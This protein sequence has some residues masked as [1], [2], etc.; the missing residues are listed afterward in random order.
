MHDRR[1]PWLTILNQKSVRTLIAALVTVSFA[2][3]GCDKV[4]G[5]VE[6]GKSLV[7][8]EEPAVADT[9]AVVDPA[10]APPAITTPEPVVPAGPTPQ[11]IVEQFTALRPGEITDGS[12]AQLAS[13]P[14]AAAAI[15]EIDMRG[16][17]VSVSGLKFLGAL[18][19][20]ETLKAS[21]LPVT[22]DSLTTIGKVQSLKNLDLS[23]SGANDQVISELSQIPHLQTLNLNGTRVTGGSA[24]GLG[25]MQ[26]L[27]EL[28]LVGTAADDLVVA[29]LASLPIR[30]LNLAKTQITNASLPHILKIKTL[31]SLNVSFCGV[32]G[33]GFKGFGK[34]DIKELDV[35]ETRF[36]IEGFMAIRGMSALE[37]LSVY[38]AGLV[39]HKSANVFRTFPKLKILNAGKN[40]LTDAG[41]HVFFKGHKTLEELHLQLNKGITDNGLAALIGVKTLRLLD[42][43]GTSCGAAGAQALKAKLPECTIR[44][45]NGQF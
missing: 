44:T 26:E 15:T 5:L 38:G 21:N 40:P 18:P 17:K 24:T 1:N 7:N 27:T 37:N 43:A 42:V 41:M 16:A 30:R 45:S 29:S 39:E 20:L 12:L 3:A 36:G 33:D 2:A 4:E 11:Q 8:G 34:S 32:T 6:D 14:E 10:A 23:N 31:E 35:G 9:P 28:S 13:S 19:N 25:A 22:P